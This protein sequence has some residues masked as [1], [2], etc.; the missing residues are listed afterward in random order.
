MDIRP[1]FKRLKREFTK[2][3]LLQA[4]LDAI[5]FFLAANLVLSV[6]SLSLTSVRNL[7]SVGVLTLLLFVGDLIYRMR[8]YSLE[9]YEQENPEFQEIL[10][11][12]RDNMYMQNTGSQALF[13]DLMARAQR[14]TSDSI[15]PARK[16][17]YKIAVVG[18]ISFLVVMS[19]LTNFQ[20][21]E[22]EVQVLPDVKKIADGIGDG[23]EEGEF[24]LK[25]A[26]SIYGEESNIDTS[27]LDISFNITGE[28]ETEEPDSDLKI[29]DR[30]Q[31]QLVLDVRE[32]QLS[33][34]RE[35]A[36]R[37]SVAI[38]EFG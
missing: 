6:L 24:D 8:R 17:I 2:V 7:W 26:S 22:D 34:D 25:N 5:I 29:Y 30:S 28:G 9:I 32:G 4:S 15:I 37:Y 12:A 27:N 36:R 23:G 33:E 35:L 16:I 20:L 19:G 11:T 13:D 38:R 10:R 14:V 3:N 21:L 1:L 31:E 18:G